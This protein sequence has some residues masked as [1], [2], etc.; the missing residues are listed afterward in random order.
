VSWVASSTDTGEIVPALQ[1]ALAAMPDVTRDSKVDAGAMKYKFATLGAVLTAVRP[2]LEANGLSI[3]QTPV[4]RGEVEST[5]LHKSGQW[6]TTAPLAIVPNNSTPQGQGSAISFARRYSILSLL[7][8]ATEDDD[9]ASA[10]KPESAHPLSER[11]A[12]VLADMKALPDTKKNELRDW[13]DGRKLSG[14]AL[15][16]NEAWLGHVEDWIAEYGGAS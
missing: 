10:S 8:L 15:L 14:A 16:A 7:C 4:G 9:G 13:A 1:K 6:I 2:V 3:M 5:L 12:A 11:V